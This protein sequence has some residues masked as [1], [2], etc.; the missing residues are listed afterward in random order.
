MISIKEN[1][2]MQRHLE[3]Q[4]EEAA[5]KYARELGGF[6]KGTTVASVNGHTRG[7]EDCG[8]SLTPILLKT[9]KA[10]EDATERLEQIDMMKE[11]F[12]EDF[13]ARAPK[14]AWEGMNAARKSIFEIRK[15]MGIK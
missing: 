1:L 2:Q 4:G 10:L 15:E 9:L 11:G 13:M 6:P 5:K 12:E 3:A 7:W 8:K 14:E